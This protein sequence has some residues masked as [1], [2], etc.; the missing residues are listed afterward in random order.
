MQGLQPNG[1]IIAVNQVSKISSKTDT[2]GLF[3]IPQVITNQ[4][5]IITGKVNETNK[6]EK[7]DIIMLLKALCLLQFN[8]VNS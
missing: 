7:P 1:L 2:S 3:Y 4:P 8:S 6:R 5:P